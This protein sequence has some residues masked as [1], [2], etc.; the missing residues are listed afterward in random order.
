MIN[1]TVVTASGQD[2]GLLQVASN[3]TVADLRSS[4]SRKL[5]QVSTAKHSLLLHG[6][7]LDY[8]QGPDALKDLAASDSITVTAVVMQTF[9]T[10]SRKSVRRSGGGE[11]EYIGVVHVWDLVTG[12]CMQ[13]LSDDRWADPEYAVFS[14]DG[15]SLVVVCGTGAEVWH[16]WSDC[17]QTLT[18]HAQE[19]RWAAFAPDGASVV[20]ASDDKTAR[21][22]DAYS[23]ECKHV[24]SGHQGNVVSAVFCPRGAFVVTASADFTARIWH[25]GDGAC[26]RTFRPDAVE[27]RCLLSAAFTL[28][29]SLVVIA[30]GSGN[31]SIWHTFT[32]ECLQ[33]L[34][35]H[36]QPHALWDCDVSPNSSLILTASTDGTAKIWHRETGE[37]TLT[38]GHGPHCVDSAAFSPDCTSI[39]TVS[40]DSKIRIWH[41]MWNAITEEFEHTLA[42]NEDLGG[43]DSFRVLWVRF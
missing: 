22:W 16:M 7:L 36:T 27:G 33:T 2:L 32:G 15:T 13:T 31:V 41:I 4:V 14:P 21:V 24:L 23:G 6:S 25:I 39:V 1:V 10:L 11:D 3:A 34:S 37:C 9:S 40:A 20:T 17:R 28:D 12:R 35:A 43:F 30:C 38:L 19:V 42:H 26:H 29:G 5:H 8:T 18:G